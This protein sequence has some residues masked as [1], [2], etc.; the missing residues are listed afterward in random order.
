MNPKTHTYQLD[1]NNFAVAT[2]EAFLALHI[3]EQVKANFSNRER[4]ALMRRL[5]FADIDA[6]E[7]SGELVLPT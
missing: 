4:I 2:C 5:Y 3:H 1:R 6:L 7:K